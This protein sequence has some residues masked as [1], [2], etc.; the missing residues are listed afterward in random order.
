MNTIA[1]KTKK[2]CTMIRLCTVSL[3]GRHILQIKLTSSARKFPFCIVLR[4]YS[5]IG[6]TRGHPRSISVIFC[7]SPFQALVGLNQFY[8]LVLEFFTYLI[9]T[10]IIKLKVYNS[11]Y[12]LVEY[13][14]D[15]GTLLLAIY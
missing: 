13:R 5:I 6:A 15:S 11:I 12:H 9:I 8:S 14:I 10:F 1:A 7:L 4:R 3:L 2:K